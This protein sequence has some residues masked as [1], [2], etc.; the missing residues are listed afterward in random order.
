MNL[1]LI[2]SNAINFLAVVQKTS[3]ITENMN[4]IIFV[5]IV[6]IIILISAILFGHKK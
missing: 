2:I 3:K 5:I 6:I 1:D 4:I